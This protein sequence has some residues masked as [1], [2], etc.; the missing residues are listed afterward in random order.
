MGEH[1][2][3]LLKLDKFAKIETAAKMDSED[4]YHFGQGK[5]FYK[6][7]TTS[8]IKITFLRKIRRVCINTV[9]YSNFHIKG[10]ERKKSID[11]KEQIIHSIGG[12]GK[13]QL[14]KCI[15]ISLVI[16]I[17]ASFFLLNM[18]FYR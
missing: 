10:L 18:V 17:P 6:F 1:T 12:F 11:V 15:Y 5:R 8:S 13:W 9:H 4:D 16:W 14:Y 3:Q 7:L 2:E